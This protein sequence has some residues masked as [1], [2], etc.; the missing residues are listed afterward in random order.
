MHQG[1]GG[2][3]NSVLL[4]VIPDDFIEIGYRTWKISLFEG[5]SIWTQGAAVQ[6]KKDTWQ[7]NDKQP[8]HG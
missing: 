2:S 3:G 4:Q 7:N 6:G 1:N 8:L 5:R